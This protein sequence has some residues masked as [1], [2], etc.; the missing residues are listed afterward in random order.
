MEHWPRRRQKISSSNS[1]LHRPFSEM[2]QSYWC[3][4]TRHRNCAWWWGVDM[5]AGVPLDQ[6]WRCIRV[7]IDAVLLLPGIGMRGMREQSQM[8]DA[9]RTSSYLFG[10]DDSSL[11]RDDLVGS[12]VGLARRMSNTIDR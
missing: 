10:S 4:E 6:V 1:K 2:S 5:S 8:K 11:V 7:I 3:I 12:L 9:V